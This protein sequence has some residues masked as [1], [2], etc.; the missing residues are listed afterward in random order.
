MQFHCQPRKLPVVRSVEEV[1]K[2]L[3]S[4]PGPGLK[5][6]AALGISDRAVMFTRP[7]LQTPDMIR[8]HELLENVASLVD[9]GRLR[10]TLRKLIAPISAAN[11]ILAHQHLESGTA[12][13]K[14]VLEGFI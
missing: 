1:A 3:A 13:G 6:R 8:Q 5:Y 7:S 12:N 4:V 14:I 9:A 10:T 2:L 11:L